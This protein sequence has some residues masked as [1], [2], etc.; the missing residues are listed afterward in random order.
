MVYT[1][2]HRAR[3]TIDFFGCRCYELSR[4]FSSV[5]QSERA[6]KEQAD[7]HLD[8]LRSTSSEPLTWVY[9]T[10][11]IEYC[12]SRVVVRYATVLMVPT[13]SIDTLNP[14]DFSIITD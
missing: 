3:C 6:I 11:H 8:F 12:R 5:M 4:A 1:A 2:Q 9:D 7:E 10:E 14:S 13:L